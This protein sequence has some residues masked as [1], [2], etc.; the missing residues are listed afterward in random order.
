MPKYDIFASC[1]ACGD[2]H[3]TGISLIL[4]NGPLNKQSIAARSPGKIFL[5]M[6]PR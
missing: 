6:L 5:R 1:N 4:D 2:L 3:P